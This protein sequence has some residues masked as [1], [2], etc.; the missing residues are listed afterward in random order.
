MSITSI[1]ETPLNSTHQTMQSALEALEGLINR[2]SA[3]AIYSFMETDRRIA[4]A[5]C[6]GLREAL[7]Q[8]QEPVAWRVRFHYGTDGMAKRIG[9]WK[10][11]EFLPTPEK[12]KD[13]EALYTSPPANANAGNGLPDFSPIFSGIKGDA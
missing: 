7:A 1:Q 3:Q 9:D 2:T 10:L 11:C 12:D 4:I 8:Q 6:V 13:I 5:A